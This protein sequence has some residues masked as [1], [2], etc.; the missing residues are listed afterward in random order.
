MEFAKGWTVKGVL[1]VRS[2]HPLQ[3][4]TLR[5]CERQQ[6]V[7][8]IHSRAAASSLGTC[9]RRAS[10]AGGNGWRKIY[11]EGRHPHEVLG[12]QIQRE[13]KQG[14]PRRRRAAGRRGGFGFFKRDEA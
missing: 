8:K 3:R 2:I 13:L 11:A 12:K 1:I 4:G 6:F 10:G 7:E 5:L 9:Q 14:F